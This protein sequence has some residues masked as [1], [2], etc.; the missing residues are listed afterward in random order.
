MPLTS[1]SCFFAL[2][3]FFVVPFVPLTT[4]D[5]RPT[6]AGRYG[7]ALTPL[8]TTSSSERG[9]NPAIRLLTP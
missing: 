8:T 4:D 3:V 2:F 1:S 5:R 7:A 6:T 9:R